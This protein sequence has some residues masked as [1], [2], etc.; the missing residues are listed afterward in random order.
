MQKCNHTPINHQYVKKIC[1][2]S[3]IY[4]VINVKYNSIFVHA[5]ILKIERYVIL[6]KVEIN[7]KFFYK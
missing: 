5:N 6:K 4:P 3:H 1:F 7:K 2:Y